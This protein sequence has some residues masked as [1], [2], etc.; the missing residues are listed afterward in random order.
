MIQS[1]LQ[2]LITYF[3]AHPTIALAA[4]FA[5]ALLEALAVIGTVIPGSSI[6]FVGGMLVGLKALDPWWAAVAAVS[7]AILGDGI[8][9][10]LGR[11]HDERIRSMW[12]LKSHPAILERGQAY[13]KKNGAK[14]VFL[15]RFLGP[16]RAIV[17]LVAGMS[18]M[19]MVRF[20]TVNVL[21]ALAWAAAHMLPGVLF[22]ASLQLAGA[23]SSRLVILL[24]AVV[25]VTW[26][27][28]WLARLLHRHA[29]PLI[30][31]QRDHLVN[32]AQGRSGALAGVVVSFLDPSRPESLG[33]LVAAVLLLGGAW[34]FLGVLQDIVAND[35]LVRFDRTVFVGLQHVRIAWADGLMV[36]IT[37]LGSGAVV[38]AVVAAV[39]LLLAIKRSWRTLA[40]WLAAIGFAQV[41]VWV[42]KTAL[43]RTRPTDLY[44]GFE[45]FSFPS[46]HT[47]S[48]VVLYGFLAF[49]IA[50]GKPVKVKVAVTLIAA[51]AILLIAFSRLYLGAHWLSDVLASLSLGTAWV[52]LLSIAYTQHG[53]DVQLPARWMALVAGVALAIAG[54]FYVSVNHEADVAR[55]APRPTASVAVLPD[56]RGDGWQRLPV[57]R[58]EI[59]GDLEEPLSVQWAA[60]SDQITAVLSTA[61]WQAPAPWT[62]RAA[63][64][65]LLPSTTIG[66]LPVLPK[67]DHGQPQQL[68]FEKVLDDDRRL[69]LRLWPT[70][71][72]IEGDGV[73]GALWNGM[74]TI[75]RLKHPAGL[76]TLVSTDS[77]FSAA[78]GRLAQS[79][80]GQQITMKVR[81]ANGLPVL[82]VW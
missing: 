60:S 24:V 31:R 25:A 46:G 73:R 9:F 56:W 66:M 51:L 35:P 59:E 3:T 45:Q 78:T 41:L 63:L 17:P 52:A 5:A 81:S 15:G 38:T 49:L 77:D 7:G 64:R 12:P 69:V 55:Y 44:S 26:A 16:V 20:Y 82:L 33:L 19:S 30:K 1:H 50:R 48:S 34:M 42:L 54:A 71:Y 39:A 80:D 43:S 57:R 23:V 14:S 11:R 74:V 72:R 75:E 18:G 58:T 8:S 4:V 2:A 29:W 70:P 65:W 79:V 32:W 61:G 67:L 68:S 37:E 76:I 10:W 40:Y 6:V 27:L 28:A 53:R 47:A 62:A 22:G 13:F 36:A 21:S